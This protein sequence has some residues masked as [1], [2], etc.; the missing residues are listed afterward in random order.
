MKMFLAALTVLGALAQPVSAQSFCT[1][2]G[3]G[4]VLKFTNNPITL[5]N[6]AP[7]RAG[8]GQIGSGQVGSGPVGLDAF[9]MVPASSGRA[10]SSDDPAATGGGST[11]YNQNLRNY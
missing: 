11:G 9:A 2:D 4:N 7:G 6:P 5:Q 10:A 3:T 1:C 8:F